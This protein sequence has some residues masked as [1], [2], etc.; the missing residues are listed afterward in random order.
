VRLTRCFDGASVS[1]ALLQ[2]RAMYFADV[3]MR[4]ISVDGKDA[5]LRLRE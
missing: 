4:C 1:G 2:W 5:I 3:D